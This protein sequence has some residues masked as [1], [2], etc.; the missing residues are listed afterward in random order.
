MLKSGEH[1]AQTTMHDCGTWCLQ[2]AATWQARAM[3]HTIANTYESPRAMVGGCDPNH[4][5]KG[6]KKGGENVGG[7]LGF[8]QQLQLLTQS[9]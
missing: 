2:T 3:A 8:V 6:G 4:E 9:T 1:S 7:G 5:R